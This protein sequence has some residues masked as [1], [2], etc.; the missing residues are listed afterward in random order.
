MH[1]TV[2]KF[3]MEPGLLVP[4]L[5]VLL[6]LTAALLVFVLIIRGKEKKKY[7]VLLERFVGEM[8]KA[9]QSLQDGEE[10]CQN[11]M[12]HLSE[13]LLLI[14][15]NGVVIFCNERV[16]NLLQ[17]SK[18]K[19]IHQPLPAIFLSDQSAPLNQA[20]GIRKG[21]K[22][23]QQFPITKSGKTFWINQKWS[24]QSTE[25][26]EPG[27][28]IVL[29]DVSRKVSMEEKVQQLTTENNERNKQINCLFDISD[30]SG[31]PGITFNNIF[32][33]SLDIIPSGLKYTHDAW[34][35]I[36]FEDKLFTSKNF[37]ETPWNY[38]A[39]IKINKKKLGH[40]R[41]GYLEEKPKSAR[42]AFHINEKLLIKNVAE[43]L[44]QVIELLNLEK[45]LAEIG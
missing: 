23:F 1:I 16:S 39:P 45:K 2:L 5:A 27:A 37:K 24:Y 6:V 36:K 33:R 22:Y 25:D 43:K 17:M 40:I 42:D 8:E 34:V 11:L 31:A 32:E 21:L 28:A 41:V 7:I 14:N 18:E 19:I 38:S 12:Q 29:S 20:G 35:E 26:G 30:I 10:K 44:G 15:K 13:G 4:V 3:I 9:N